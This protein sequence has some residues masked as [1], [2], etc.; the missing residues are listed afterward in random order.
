MNM[1]HIKEQAQRFSKII[2]DDE[3][4][5]DSAHQYALEKCGIIEDQTDLSE[6][7]E[8]WDARSEYTLA[9][10]REILNLNTPKN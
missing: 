4:L 1:D 10:V 8:Y 3:L 9:V 7:E 5:C 2:N 6:N